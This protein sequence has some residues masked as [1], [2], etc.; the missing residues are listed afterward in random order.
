MDLEKLSERKLVAIY[1][2]LQTAASANCTALIN[3][4]WGSE[5][6][7]ETRARAKT[8]DALAVQYVEIQNNLQ[9]LIAEQD[10][11]KR[12]HGSLKPIKRRA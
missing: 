2:K 4:G 9:I 6:G 5:R 12:W 8:G 10:A 11:R 7:S 3:A 1:E